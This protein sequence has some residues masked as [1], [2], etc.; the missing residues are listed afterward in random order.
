MK[1]HTRTPVKLFLNAWEYVEIVLLYI[2]MKIS[3]I[4]IDRNDRNTPKKF[5]P[6]IM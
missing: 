1:L 6:T 2:F 3:F 4:H 5:F